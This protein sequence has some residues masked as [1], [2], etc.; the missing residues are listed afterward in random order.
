MG[1]ASSD[2]RRHQSMQ[3]AQVGTRAD[4]E[5]VTFPSS[6][7]VADRGFGPSVLDLQGASTMTRRRARNA[8]IDMCHSTMVRRRQCTADDAAC[9]PACLVRG[10]DGRASGWRLDFRGRRL[11]L[12]A[13]IFAWRPL[14]GACVRARRSHA[15]KGLHSSFSRCGCGLKTGELAYAFAW[16]RQRVLLLRIDCTPRTNR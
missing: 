12:V 7:W 16:G 13:Y 9:I 14:W 11:A 1:S 5:R 2:S 8:C 3:Q 10:T 6:S 4:V 15:T